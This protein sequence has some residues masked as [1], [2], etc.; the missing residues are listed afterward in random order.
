MQGQ[1]NGVHAWWMQWHSFLNGSQETN[2]PQVGSRQVVCMLTH[3]KGLLKCMFGTIAWMHDAK[4]PMHDSRGTHAWCNDMHARG[5]GI[6]ARLWLKGSQVWPLHDMMISMQDSMECMG[7][8]AQLIMHIC[9]GQR[10]KVMVLCNPCNTLPWGSAYKGLN[11]VSMNI[12]N[13]YTHMYLV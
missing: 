8:Y 13:M 3:N 9:I 6:H 11:I 1:L 5:Q 10:S 2:C 7:H 12:C 4:A